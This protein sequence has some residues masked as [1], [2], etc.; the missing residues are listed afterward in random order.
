MSQHNLFPF[1]LVE[2][3]VEGLHARHSRTTR[4]IYLTVVCS[5]LIVA[6]S[7]PLIE[8]EVN[9]QSRGVLRPTMKLAPVVS[10]VSGRVTYA[11]LPE[12]G[13]VC[14]GDTLLKVSRLGVG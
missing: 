5:L 14:A 7:L 6:A 8:V 4:S 1:P 10:P 11:A 12:N 9:S 2:G 13:A 3:N